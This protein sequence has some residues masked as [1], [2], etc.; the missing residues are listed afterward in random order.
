MLTGAKTRPFRDFVT[1]IFHLKSNTKTPNFIG[2]K[3]KPQ[4][5]TFCPYAYEWSQYT[6]S[7][8]QNAQ[9]YTHQSPIGKINR[10]MKSATKLIFATF[11]FVLM[12]TKTDGRKYASKPT[13]QNSI[14]T[15]VR[16]HFHPTATFD[17]MW[18]FESSLCHR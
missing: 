5:D 13:N 10:L 9:L 15:F 3:Q 16:S 11:P 1:I 18:I 6:R 8:N 14:M 12:Q 4:H 7:I 2:M 17:S